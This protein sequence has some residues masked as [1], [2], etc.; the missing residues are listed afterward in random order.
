MK[1]ISKIILPILLLS[2]ISVV[3]AQIIGGNKKDKKD[4]YV[5]TDGKAEFDNQVQENRVD[6]RAKLK[7]Y[8]YNGTKSTYFSYKTYTYAKEFEIITIQK[9]DYK[10]AFNSNSVKHDKIQVRIY[11]RPKKANGRILL[12]EKESVGGGEF[13]V[14]LE[15]LNA[16]FRAE[17]A[18][19][20]SLDPTVIAKMRLKKVYIQYIIPAVDREVSVVTDGAN[21]DQTTIIKFS[22]MVVAV[23]YKNL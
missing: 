17:K 2:S 16:I 15:D 7:P 18:K 11:D 21:Q 8:K 19:H 5:E 6:A 13:V 4:K 10:L 12:F 23:G 3:N 9:T 22:A 14:N 1:F 20:S